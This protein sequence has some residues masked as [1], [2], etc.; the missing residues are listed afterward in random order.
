MPFEVAEGAFLD[1]FITPGMHVIECGAH[2]GFFTL[3]LC[4]LVGPTGT[5]L[6][7]EPSPRERE[8]LDRNL[9]RN[10][11]TNVTVDPRALGA[12]EGMA[13]LFICDYETGCNSLRPPAVDEEIH[14]LL[15]RVTTL[16]LAIAE[17][18]ETFPDFIKI[19][20]EGA[21]LQILRGAEHCLRTGRPTIFCELAD[22]RTE[23]W[24]YRAVEIFDH[25]TQMGYSW[26]SITDS[27][28]LNPQPRQEDFHGN[29]IARHKEHDKFIF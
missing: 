28:E 8:R 9:W 3:Q 17:I 6:A 29:F 27:G 7:F 25:V 4:D 13:K 11:C 16:D 18:G 14:Q 10:S 26:F 22:I 21:E 24:G 15:V 19:D 20:A 23:P 12:E 5:V 1:R 2:Q